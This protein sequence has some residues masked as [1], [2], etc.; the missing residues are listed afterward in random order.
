MA[1]SYLNLVDLYF[2]SRLVSH[3]SCRG[4]RSADVCLSRALAV[5]R[6]FDLANKDFRHNSKKYTVCV[7]EKPF[8]ICTCFLIP[9]VFVN[10]N[11]CCLCNTA[12]EL[13]RQDGGRKDV[14]FFSP[15]LG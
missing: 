9:Y 8:D 13:P 7:K 3:A 5:H 12:L 14:M 2:A 10:K 4:A 11:V 1:E 15:F 6:Y